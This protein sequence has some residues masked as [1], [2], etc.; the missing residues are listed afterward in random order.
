MMTAAAESFQIEEGLVRLIFHV[1]FIFDVYLH[2][3]VFNMQPQSHHILRNLWTAILLRGLRNVG[4]MFNLFILFECMCFFIENFIKVEIFLISS[5]AG[6]PLR[7]ALRNLIFLGPANEIGFRHQ[8]VVLKY[9]LVPLR[10]SFSVRTGP[11]GCCLHNA[12]RQ[13]EIISSNGICVP[14]SFVTCSVEEHFATW[15]A[16]YGYV[17][18]S[19]SSISRAMHVDDMKFFT[20]VRYSVRIL[21]VLNNLH[22]HSQIVLSCPR[23]SS[24]NILT[25][26]FRRQKE[27]MPGELNSHIHR[28]KNTF[29]VARIGAFLSVY[30]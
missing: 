18:L 6:R 25:A 21:S 8:V 3:V 2:P 15:L 13:V 5:N 4:L 14:V 24:D 16:F 7:F 11:C 28:S 17:P 12:T 30:H 29:T 23:V 27:S 9:F 10:L 19:A 20:E 26:I 22:S 1:H